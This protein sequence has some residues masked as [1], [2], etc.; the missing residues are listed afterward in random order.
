MN[1][2]TKEESI[3]EIYKEYIKKWDKGE[4]EWNHHEGDKLGRKPISPERIWQ[5][6]IE[7]TLQDERQKREE[8]VER[9]EAREKQLKTMH[10]MELDTVSCMSI[11]DFVVWRDHRKQ[12]PTQPNNTKD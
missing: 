5:T 11:E 9:A 2:P 12:R 1:T 8:V 4:F 10:T 3:E 7:P 6:F